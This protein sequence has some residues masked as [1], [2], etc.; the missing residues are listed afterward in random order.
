MRQ[1]RLKFGIRKLLDKARIFFSCWKKCIGGVGWLA[2]KLYITGL[3][4]GPLFK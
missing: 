2:M 3:K 4:S 1:R